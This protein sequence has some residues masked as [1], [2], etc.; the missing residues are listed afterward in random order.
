[1]IV[2]V[3]IVAHWC[4]LCICGDVYLPLICMLCTDVAYYSIK[5]HFDHLFL[6]LPLQ[7]TA[8]HQ[9]WWSNSTERCGFWQLFK[10]KFTDGQWTNVKTGKLLNPR[11]SIDGSV[12]PP[13]LFWAACDLCPPSPQSWSF[14]A[15]P[16]LSPKSVHLFSKYRVHKFGDTWM[17][18]RTGGRRAWEHV[19]LPPY[20]ARRMHNKSRKQCT[21]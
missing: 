7:S 10:Q 5:Y 21:N 14:V 15:F 8:E 3:C 2:A 4:V 16:Q 11:G 18:E 6:M 20:L 19:L 9:S 12:R 17:N 13:N 1:M